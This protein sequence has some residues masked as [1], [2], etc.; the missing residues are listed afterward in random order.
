MWS[1]KCGVL[2][3]KCGVYV[4]CRAW[5]VEHGVQSLECEV[6]SVKCGV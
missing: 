1:V 2:S 4:E 5:S 6:W 3:V